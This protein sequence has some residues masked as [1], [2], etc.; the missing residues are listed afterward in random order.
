VIY[1]GPATGSVAYRWKTDCEENA[2]AF[3]AAGTLPEMNH[4]ELEAW[5]GPPARQ[6][7]LVLLR[8]PAESPEIARRFTLLRE[9][10]ADAPGGTSEVWARGTGTVA[11]LLSLIA[12]GQWTSYYLAMLRGVDPWPMPRLDAL[13]MRLARSP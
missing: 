1:G 7:Y 10:I 13:K 12:L 6:L 2:K 11:R 5:G 8:D 4:N 3:A 9:L